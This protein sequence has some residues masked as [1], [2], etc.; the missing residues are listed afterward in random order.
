MEYHSNRTDAVPDVPRLHFEHIEAVL[1]CCVEPLADGV[2]R[3]LRVELLGPGAAIGI[4]ASDWAG[5]FEQYVSGIRPYHDL[6]CHV[7]GHDPRHAAWPASARHV[8]MS[9]GRGL[10]AVGCES[11]LIFGG[12]W[13]LLPGA[14]RLRRVPY[15]DRAAGP[16]LALPIGIFLDLLGG[17]G[18]GLLTA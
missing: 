13:R 15:Q 9:S 4:D 2:A 18:T 12:Q 11:S 6:H 16:P 17:P 5:R 3:E 1:A 7:E 10:G 8:E 14:E